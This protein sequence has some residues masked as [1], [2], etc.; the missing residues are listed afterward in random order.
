MTKRRELQPRILSFTQ[1]ERRMIKRVAKHHRLPV[2]LNSTV[3]FGQSMIGSVHFELS[4]YGDLKSFGGPDARMRRT[5]ALVFNLSD[6]DTGWLVYGPGVEWATSNKEKALVRMW[7][8]YIGAFTPHDPKHRL[9]EDERFFYR[10]RRNGSVEPPN[11]IQETPNMLTRLPHGIW[12]TKYRA[13]RPELKSWASGRDERFQRLFPKFMSRTVCFIRE[14]KKTLK[15]GPPH[16][17]Q[18]LHPEEGRTFGIAAGLQ[19]HICL[20]PT[21]TQNGRRLVVQ[22]SMHDNESRNHFDID[23]FTSARHSQ[24]F[25]W[26]EVKNQPMPILRWK[27]GKDAMASVVEWVLSS[28]QIP[29]PE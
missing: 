19:F 14:L 15:G 6:G 11:P 4:W 23:Y 21:R 22:A 24:Y 9:M 3:F 1:I 18:L 17:I 7:Q 25:A 13:S 20:P 16:V 8:R 12:L 2:P 28:I 5:L 29:G 10:V 27:R 26:E